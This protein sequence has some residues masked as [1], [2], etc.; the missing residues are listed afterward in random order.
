MIDA[1]VALAWCLGDD[2]S[3]HADFV[4]TLLGSTDAKVPPHWELEVVNGLMVAEKHGRLGPGDV[5]RLAKL[6]A[7]LP[8]DVSAPARGGALSLVRRLAEQH[9]LSTLDAAYVELALR[10]GDQLISMDTAIANAARREG[11]GG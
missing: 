3:G 7:A 8:I 4:L 11:V 10:G 2:T 6:L 5:D 9:R 1:S